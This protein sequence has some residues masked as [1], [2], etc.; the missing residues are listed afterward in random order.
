MLLAIKGTG[1]SNKA[2][3]KEIANMSK[4]KKKHFF[5]IKGNII[6]YQT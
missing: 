4:K 6:T 3:P 1:L 5:W 2:L